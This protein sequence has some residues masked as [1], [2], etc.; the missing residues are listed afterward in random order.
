MHMIYFYVFNR[1]RGAARLFAALIRETNV[2]PIRSTYPTCSIPIC[3][4]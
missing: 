2:G 3:R 1:L 4:A